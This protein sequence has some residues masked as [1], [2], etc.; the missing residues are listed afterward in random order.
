MLYLGFL[1]ATMLVKRWTFWTFYKKD[2]KKCRKCL[3]YEN[4][5]DNMFT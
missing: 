4:I 1:L 2:E 5:P 3:H